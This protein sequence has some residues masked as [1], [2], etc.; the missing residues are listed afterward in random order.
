[1]RERRAGAK[2]VLVIEDYSD[3]A[4]LLCVVLQA[5]GHTVEVAAT[6][7]QG[8]EKARAF[9]PDVIICDLGLPD[10]DGLA[11]AR[12]IRADQTLDDVWLIALTAYFV[13]AHA[14]TAGYD[15]YVTKPADLRK[16]AAHVAEEP[17]PRQRSRSTAES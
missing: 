14:T 7:L 11:V 4:Q 3:S 13:P 12:A 5:H 9:Q 6:G 1:M 15:E 16:L 8:I 10:I 2:K 17:P